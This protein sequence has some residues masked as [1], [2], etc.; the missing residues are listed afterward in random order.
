MTSL[1]TIIPGFF[2]YLVIMGYYPGILSEEVPTYTI[3]G[4]MAPWLL[5]VY[6]IVLFGT[7]IE[8]GTGFIHAVNERINSWLEDRG[9]TGLTR[10]KRG[11]LGGLMALIGL[12]VASFGLI[13]LIAKGYGTIS[14]GFFILHGGALFTV[15]LYK[16]RKKNA[17]TQA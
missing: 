4:E 15:G 10:G 17:P 5:P 3:L 9:G 16:I 8:T 14:W 1:I 2:L 13:G 6:M 11:L 12:G 7:M